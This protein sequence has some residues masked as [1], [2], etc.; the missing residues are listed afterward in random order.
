MI[1]TGDP[2]LDWCENNLDELRKYP[3]SFVAI[4]PQ[5]G[6]VHHDSD[7]DSFAAWGRG[8]S[9]ADKARLMLTHTSMY[10]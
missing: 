6:I 5:I 7:S 1:D 8:L 4:D 2:Y 9:K 3:D 10:V